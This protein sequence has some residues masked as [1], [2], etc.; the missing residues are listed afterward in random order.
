MSD[1]SETHAL[2]SRTEPSKRSGGTGPCCAVC[3]VVFAC[4]W[5]L[6]VVAGLTVY[7][8]YL[9]PEK[10]LQRTEHNKQKENVT[11]LLTEL[12]SRL[13]EKEYVKQL[14]QNSLSRQLYSRVISVYSASLGVEGKVPK[15]VWDWIQEAA[16][17]ITLDPETANPW[18]SLSKDKKRISMGKSYQTLSASPKRFAILVCVLGREGFTSG[19]H[20]WEVEVGEKTAWDIGVA[21]ESIERKNNSLISP[22]RG[23]WSIQL[24]KNNV[25]KALSSPS[26]VLPLSLKL[27][28]VGVYVDYEDGL[29]S[30]FNVKE[31]CHLYTFTANFNERLYPYFSPSTLDNGQNSAPL[32]ISPVS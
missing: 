15:P 3:A 7:F 17:D 14:A 18:L 25:Y 2:K 10:E 11:W 13:D 30:F 22:N 19:R 23:Y 20:Y 1:F 9:A 21:K 8:F 16:A 5:I 12:M 31:R 26:T 28:K 32:I 24:R 4:L 27:Q 29:V 6:T